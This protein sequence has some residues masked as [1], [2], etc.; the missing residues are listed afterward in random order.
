MPR[1]RYAEP[2]GR[3][4]ALR[5]RDLLRLGTFAGALILPMPALARIAPNPVEKALKLYSL[6]S[7]ESVNTTFWADGWYVPDAFPEIDRFLRD[8]HSGA[9]KKID[10]QLVELLYEIQTRLG[11]QQGL[12]VTCGY[13]SPGTNAMLLREGRVHAAHS[14]HMCGKAVD[15][16]VPDR[17]LRHVRKVAM[18]LEGGGV[19]YYPRA[20]FLHVDV[21]PVR[22]W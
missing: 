2:I 7:S 3:A 5:R 6:H 9:I 21:G 4:R 1:D 14:Y 12:E 15:F 18:A 22:H 16:R 13:R 20:Q 10:R 17:D 11:T 8:Q 19:G